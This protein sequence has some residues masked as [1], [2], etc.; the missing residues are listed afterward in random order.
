MSSNVYEDPDL[1]MKTR[2][3]RRVREE[4]E[5]KVEKQVE[6]YESIV[7]VPGHQGDRITR[8]RSE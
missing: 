8:E 3:S 6:I 2:Y 1:K 7:T 4:S 5:E